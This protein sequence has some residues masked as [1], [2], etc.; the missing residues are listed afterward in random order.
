MLFIS[1]GFFLLVIAI[2][3]PGICAQGTA[4][5]AAEDDEEED[6]GDAGR[7]REML[8]ETA[9]AAENRDKEDNGEGDTYNRSIH[10]VEPDG[11]V[12]AEMTLRS[13]LAVS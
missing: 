2:S 4:A 5:A 13:E 10:F 6:Y 1:R 8:N 12:C 7:D 3:I 11:G 9:A